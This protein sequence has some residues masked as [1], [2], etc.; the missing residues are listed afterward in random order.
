MQRQC[1][2]HGL[3]AALEQVC[4]ATT[5]NH[6]STHLRF[7]ADTSRSLSR[8]LPACATCRVT[9]TCLSLLVYIL[10]GRHGMLPGHHSKLCAFRGHKSAFPPLQVTACTRTHP[11]E[12]PSISV[13]TV[14]ILPTCG[15]P[16]RCFLHHSCATPR[17]SVQ[18]GMRL[19]PFPH[20]EHMP[21][22]T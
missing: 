4:T 1:L 3:W 14:L 10:A 9:E 17:S 20:K 15:M 8:T 21:T 12:Q 13:T 11:P 19:P 16:D 18:L 2:V 5:N 22:H 7:A 6:A